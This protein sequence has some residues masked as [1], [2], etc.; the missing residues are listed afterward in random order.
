MDKNVDT[1]SLN[2]FN[3]LICFSA[4]HDIVGAYSSV[5]DRLGWLQVRTIQG[6]GPDLAETLFDNFPSRIV[7]GVKRGFHA[8]TAH[9][10]LKRDREFGNRAQAVCHNLCHCFFT[11]TRFYSRFSYKHKVLCSLYLAGDISSG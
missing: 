1:K 6:Q 9:T 7:R 11:F 4:V 5:F 8:S 3:I 2:S 10:S